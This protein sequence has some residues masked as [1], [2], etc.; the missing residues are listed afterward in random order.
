[1]RNLLIALTMCLLQS[2]YASGQDQASPVEKPQPEQR[3]GGFGGPIELD[4]DDKQVYEDPPGT[5][6]ENRADI[7]HG[8]LE[9]IEYESKTVGTT[10][11]M[12]VYTPPNYSKD[13]RYP[14]LYLLHGIG[15]DETEWQRFATPDML[16]DNLIADGKAVPMIVVMP[17]GRAQK[18]DRAE[19]N[20][21]AHAPAF[22]VFEKD[23]LEDVIPAIESRYSV[24]GDREHRALAGLSMGG[25]QSLNFGLAHLDQFAWVGGFSSAPNTKA[26]EVLIPDPQKTKDQLKLLWLSCGNKDGLIRFSQQMHRYLKANSVPH[27]WNVDS[28]GHDPTHWRNNLYHFAQMIFQTSSAAVP[29]RE[30]AET[31]NTDDKPSAA[32]S[33]STSNTP[34]GILDDFK[35]AVTNQPGKDFPQVNSQGRIKFRVVAPEAKSVATTFR[36]ST[37]FIKGE[38][39]AWIGYSRPLDEGFHYYE[40]VIDGAHVPDPNSLYYFGAMRWGSGIE[41]PAHD[42]DFYALKKVPHGQMR[43]IF[44]HSESTNSERRAFVYTPPGYDSDT[45]KKYPVLYLQHGWGENEYGWSVQGHAGRIMDNLIAEGKVAPFL[46]VMTYGMTNEIRMGGLQNFDIRP[47]EKVL[48]EEL[49]PYVDSNFRTLSDRSNRAMAG[50]SMG[51][52]ETKLITLRNLDKFSHIGLFS[53]ATINGEDVAKTEGFKDKVALVFVSYGSKEVGDG[54]P[55]RGGNPSEAVEQLKALGINAHYYLSPDTAHEWQTWRRSLKEFAPLLF[56]REEKI[57]GMWHSVFETPF[58]L[59]TYHFNF[60][61]E[62]SGEVIVR[63]E[64][65]SGDQKRNV[66]FADVK[67]ENDQIVFSERRQFGANELLIQYTGKLDGRK[68]TLSRV[69]GDRGAQQSIATRDLPKA[70]PVSTAPVVEVQ[71]ERLIKDVYKNSFLIGTAVT[72]QPVIRTRNYSSQPNTLVLSHRKIA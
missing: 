46:M 48:V 13:K 35:P 53:G 65:D 27:I 61:Q 49:I 3:R 30:K 16:L 7:P 20:V 59:Q 58:G 17:N 55:R 32:S 60:L 54:R 31:T 1:M 45:D 14:V 42:R 19:G 6:V 33:K 43:E 67:L 68:L 9:M 38:D 57:L 64:I 15:G 56:Q 34:E 4:A 12:N 2:P 69:V 52:M 23:L 8:K 50:L 70:E 37:E 44:F 21:M 72:C 39:G 62:N 63:A 5:I 22:A 25:G 36:D 26:P 28:H 71:I 24:V 29:Q 10:R 11:K 47:F 66:Q 18:N 41:I 40:L 51:S